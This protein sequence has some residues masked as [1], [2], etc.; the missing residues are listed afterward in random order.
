MAGTEILADGAEYIPGNILFLPGDIS[1]WKPFSIYIWQVLDK[2]NILRVIDGGEIHGQE[3]VKRWPRNVAHLQNI[4]YEDGR[5]VSVCLKEGAA[6]P[7]MERVQN[8]DELGC[9]RPDPRR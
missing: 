3:I 8:G 9:P 2:E 6:R 7:M 5:K 1:I 4:L